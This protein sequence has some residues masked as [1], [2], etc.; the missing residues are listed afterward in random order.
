MSTVF[1]ELIQVALGK[2]EM[3]SSTPNEKDWYEL[4]DIS[5]RQA[6]AGFVFDALDKL[7]KKKQ[8]V[9]LPLLYEWIGLS[10]QIRAQNLLLNRRCNELSEQFRCAGYKSCILKGQGNARLYPN[11]L[12]R[13]S[14]DIDIWIDAPK[15]EIRAF[16]RER[17]PNAHETSQHIEYPVFEDAEVEVHFIPASTTTI[18]HQHRLDCYF[19][20]HRESQFNNSIEL[21][22]V[23]GTINV[24]TDDFNIIHQ[25]LHMEKHFFLG[26]IGL[27]HILD[28]YYLLL[29]ARDS[30]S[31][32]SVTDT[33]RDLGMI[34][35][36]SAVMWVLSEKLGME[37]YYLITSP[38]ANRGKLLMKEI[39]KTGNFGQYEQRG[40]KKIARYSTILYLL[41]RNFSLL[42]YFPEES[43]STVLKSVSSKIRTSIHSHE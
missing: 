28:F 30:I 42:R 5:I 33:I 17:Y 14:G 32:T 12:L 29:Y 10:E 35:F 2:Q 40:Y 9:P 37:S 19:K 39:E 7:S 26:G 38:D 36:A 11:S 22:D 20:E 21:P 23:N 4:Y 1:Y 16:V 6:V 31:K 27:R 41:I 43:L 15:E 3:L 34:N 8:G 18:R 25:L 24:P 13:Q